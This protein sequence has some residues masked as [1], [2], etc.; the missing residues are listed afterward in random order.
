MSEREG[1]RRWKVLVL[2]GSARTAV[3]NFRAA[4]V[5][6]SEAV[7]TAEPELTRSRGV[8]RGPKWRLE[9]VGKKH[10]VNRSSRKNR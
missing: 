9:I 4:Q 2:S 8:W 6:I 1:A 5:A 10:E 7:E 3:G